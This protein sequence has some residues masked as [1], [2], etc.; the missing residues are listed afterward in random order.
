MP[1]LERHFRLRER[2]T[3]VV[4]EVCGAVATFATSS[5]KGR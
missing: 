2:Q 5:G 1:W 3:T 4:R